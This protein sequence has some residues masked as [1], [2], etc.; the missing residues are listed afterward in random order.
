MVSGL[1]IVCF[2]RGGQTDFLIDGK[3][4]YLVKYKD[5]DLFGER[6]R[7][8]IENDLLK[9]EIS[10]FNKRYSRDFLIEICARR[11]QNIYHSL[12]ERHAAKI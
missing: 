1:P 7:T 6:I 3:T 9:S 8:L 10:V 5:F 12:R 11:Y 2:D 4:G